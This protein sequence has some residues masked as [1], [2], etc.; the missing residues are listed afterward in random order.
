[1][2]NDKLVQVIEYFSSQPTEY[3]HVEFKEDNS[4]PTTM[5]KNISAIANTLI[6]ENIPRGYIIWGVT[7]DK[8]D[9]VGTKFN[10]DT[11]KCGN[12]DIVLWLSKHIRPEL[13]I[14]FHRATIDGKQLVALIIKVNR[15]QISKFDNVPYIRIDKNTRKL[16]DFPETEKQVWKEVL[17][18]EFEI[19]PAKTDL[20]RE[21]IEELLDLNA[22]YE[23]RKDRVP[24]ERDAV[25]AEIINCGIIQNN[26]DSTFNITNLGALL[27][28]KDIRQFGRLQRKMPRVIAYIGDSKLDTKSE[29]VGQRGYAVGF[30]GLHNYIMLQVKEGEEIIGGLR[31]NKYR[32][33]SLTVREL[34]ANTIIHQDFAMDGLQP[35]IEIYSNRIEFTNPGSPIVPIDR[36]VDYPPNSRNQRMADEMFKMGICERRG[37]GW[38]KVAD[39]IG[40]LS[41]PAPTI[42]KTETATHVVLMHSRSLND[43]TRE[44]RMWSIYIH[45]CLLWVEKRFTTN[46]TVREL[47]NI[48]EHNAAVA[49]KLLAQAV[50]TGLITIFDE[51]SSNKYRKYVPKYAKEIE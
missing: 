29:Q 5:A 10:P 34:L 40:R 12:E 46:S 2:N 49:S 30:D 19:M 21:E 35:M 9:I 17:S 8:H 13:E 11:K 44:E 25:F 27:L 47:F 3:P 22:F 32:F 16:S 38:D 23:L 26:R 28:A 1:M 33:P 6:K 48:D 4:D 42:E 15:S 51:G 24:V 7:N 20:A 14:K 31:R 43:M 18:S 45:A 50:K 36:F 39:E 41:F 37:S